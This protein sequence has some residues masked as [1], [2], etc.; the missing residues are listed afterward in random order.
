MASRALPVSSTSARAFNRSPEWVRYGL[1]QAQPKAPD[2][3]ENARIVSSVLCTSYEISQRDAWALLF[4]LDADA[5]TV[6][7]L[8][9]AAVAKLL[10]MGIAAREQPSPNSPRKSASGR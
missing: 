9:A 5:S 3:L 10:A 2:T 4:D 8:H 1:E 7:S 6:Q